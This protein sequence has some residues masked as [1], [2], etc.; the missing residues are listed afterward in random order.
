MNKQNENELSIDD[1]DAV[2]NLQ[3]EIIDIKG[4][5]CKSCAELIE[6]KLKKLQGVNKV[7][8]SFIENKAFVQFD[9][10]QI[11]LDKVKGEIEKAGYEIEKTEKLEHKA[12]V[13][14]TKTRHTVY[15][16]NIE[17]RTKILSWLIAVTLILA[18]I[19]SY[20][21]I[22]LNDKLNLKSNIINEPAVKENLPSEQKQPSR[23]QVSADNDPV[24]GS[25]DA[26]VTIV[27][28]SDFQCP[29]CTR[30][31]QQTL[32]QIEE[33]YIKTGKVKL[34]YRDYP[35]SFHQNAQKAAEAAEA[36]KEQGKFWEYHDI[37]FQK[38]DE[39]STVGVDKFKE[40]A[41]TL[42]L[43]T[44]KFNEELDSGKY[45]DEVQKDFQDGQTA[46]VTGTPTFFINGIELM[47]AQPFSSFQNII[48]QELNK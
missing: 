25:K 35:L 45:A 6:I 5:H 32:P 28:F 7:K 21:I 3:E 31:Y 2:K 41:Q 33:K 4:M 16:E 12:D 26:P 23:T 27:E 1:K 42:G 43:D 40:Y 24:K 36:A 8:V 10:A 9:P 48:D 19:N 20:N 15:K 38:Q 14:N 17:T 39:W 30:F 34:V 18:L 13:E 47:G 22:K 37:L 44:K 46:G 29:F 11:N